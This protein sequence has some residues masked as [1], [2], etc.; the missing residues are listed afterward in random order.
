MLLYILISPI[1]LFS[2]LSLMHF[3][4][5]SPLL[6]HL[7]WSTHLYFN[8][9]SPFSLKH[10]ILLLLYYFFY[11]L[12]PQFP[13]INFPYSYSPIKDSIIYLW[14]IYA[15][16]RLYYTKAVLQIR[17]WFCIFSAL[18][19]CFSVRGEWALIVFSFL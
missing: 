10:P 16:V 1:F 8:L 9:F 14:D 5:F 19:W 6:W 4:Y 2:S 18:S 7:S 13:N 3:Q 12:C 15:N 17:L 11:C